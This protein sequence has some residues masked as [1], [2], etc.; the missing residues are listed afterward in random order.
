MEQMLTC[1]ESKDLSHYMF[2]ENSYRINIKDLHDTANPR[3][4]S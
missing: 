4:A 1:Q 3:S 2:K